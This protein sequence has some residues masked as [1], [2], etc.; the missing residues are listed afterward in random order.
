[1]RP[2]FGS[3]RPDFGSE[4]PD[5]GSERPDFGSERPDFRSG[6][7]GLRLGG[8]TD[9]RTETGENCPMWNHRSSA[10]PGPLPKNGSSETDIGRDRQTGK[11]IQI[12]CL[13]MKLHQ[14]HDA[15]VM[16]HRHAASSC[17][18]AWLPWLTVS[19]DTCP[20]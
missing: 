15:I 19:T 6:K 20:N 12:F 16:L 2:D 14:C 9:G 4:K 17:C 13:M 11:K 1:M 10:P 5:F 8:G 18:L 3:E 7:P